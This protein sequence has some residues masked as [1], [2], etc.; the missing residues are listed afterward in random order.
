MLVSK[1]TMGSKQVDHCSLV[2]FDRFKDQ[3]TEAVL[4]M[5]EENH[6]DILLVPANC[7]N[8]LQPLDISVNKAVKIS[9]GMSFKVGMPNLAAK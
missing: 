8:R 3:C 9:S 5:L 4:K 6:I 7:T 1:W 2:I